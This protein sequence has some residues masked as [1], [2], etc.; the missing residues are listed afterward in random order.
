MD[1]HNSNSNND[2][3][4]IIIINSLAR[5]AGRP[6]AI[7][8]SYRPLQLLLWPLQKRRR[9]RRPNSMAVIRRIVPA[10]FALSL[11]LLFVALASPLPGQSN[12]AH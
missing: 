7:L 3:D 9:R 12:Q 4:T 2:N 8:C 10:P 11:S 5:P 1:N 6:F